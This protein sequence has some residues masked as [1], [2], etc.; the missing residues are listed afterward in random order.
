MF[1]KEIKSSELCKTFRQEIVLLELEYLLN[2]MWY[3]K[4]FLFATYV[5]A[6]SYNE[7]LSNISDITFESS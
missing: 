5:Q 6:I 4:D 3:T 2:V 1:S 7:T